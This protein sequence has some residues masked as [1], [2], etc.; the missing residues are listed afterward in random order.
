[1]ATKIKTAQKF[2]HAV[3]IK[4]HDIG[5]DHI[6]AEF[7]NGYGASVIKNRYSYGGPEGF[8]E[9]AVTHAGPLCYATPVTSDVIGWL[10]EAAVAAT[11]DAIAAL[12]ADASCSHESE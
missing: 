9:V 8:Y 6:E 10:D 2:G 12:P 4:P 7:P 1:M 3:T 11:L 5:G